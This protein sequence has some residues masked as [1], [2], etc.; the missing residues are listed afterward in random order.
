M[1]CG[2]P[3]QCLDDFV[4]SVALTALER[5]QEHAFRPDPEKP[6]R[7]SVRAWLG[8][9]V[10]FRAMDLRRKVTLRGRVV[11]RGPTE[12]HPVDVE[13]TV[14]SPE[15]RVEAREELR[16][17]ERLKMSPM[18]REAVAMAAEG[19]TAREIGE[20]LGVPEDTA[21]TYIKRARKAWERGKG[22]RTAKQW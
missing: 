1:T 11:V 19:Y 6:L 20:R 8:G 13:A 4:S 22:K 17:I 9:I 14:P 12:E 3:P 10:R 16:A 2:V 5:I 7:E 15:A 18:Q 21:G